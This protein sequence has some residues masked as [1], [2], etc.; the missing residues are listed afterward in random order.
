VLFKC[1][2]YFFEQCTND[3]DR[4]SRRVIIPIVTTTTNFLAGNIEP[5]AFICSHVLSKELKCFY[6]AHIALPSPSLFLHYLNQ[7]E[8][9][10][11]FI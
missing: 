5:P 6:M 4:N 1:S 3:L 8:H 9:V 10:S 2:L 11:L 7:I